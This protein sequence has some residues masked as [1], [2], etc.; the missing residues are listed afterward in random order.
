MANALYKKKRSALNRLTLFDYIN[1]SIVFLLMLLF[2]YPMIFSLSSS[3]SNSQALMKKQVV[4]LPRDFSIDA[5][6]YLLENTKIWRYYLNTIFYSVGGTLIFLVLTSMMAYPFLST[7]VKGKSFL[8]VYMLITM[9]F[10][11]GLVPTYF[12]MR[13]LGLKNNVLVMLLPGAVSAYNVI[14]FRTFFKS[15]PNELREAAYIDGADHYQ[16]LILIMIPCSKALLATFALFSMVGKWNDYFTPL[17]YFNKDYLNPM[18]IYLRKILITSSA[19]DALDKSA[20]ALMEMKTINTQNVK[21]AAIWITITPIMCVYPFLQK[22]F[23]KGVMIGS[24]KG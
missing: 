10:G 9:F 20:A 5:Y 4:L 2:V 21:H 11:G 22:Y 14:V 7:E 15:I 19:T 24:V 23:A 18:Q 16:V 6:R 8:N 13:A 12:V 17:I 1:Y 3:L